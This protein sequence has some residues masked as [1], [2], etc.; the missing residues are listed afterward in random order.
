VFAAPAPSITEFVNA[1]D[2]IPEEHRPAA[3]AFFA[4]VQ[5][6]AQERGVSPAEVL[7]DV[8]RPHLQILRRRLGVEAAEETALTITDPLGMAVSFALIDPATR[9]LNFGRPA[10]GE[11]PQGAR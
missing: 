9:C 6:Q 11:R 3:C 7:A 1:L 4:S 10:D 8:L 5:A 2:L